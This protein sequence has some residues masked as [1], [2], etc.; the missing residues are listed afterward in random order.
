MDEITKKMLV[1][2]DDFE[3]LHEKTDS[4]RDSAALA[5]RV[6]QYAQ[7]LSIEHP[8]LDDAINHAHELFSE[9]EYSRALEVIGAAVEDI[10][11]GVFKQIE[12]SYY[13]EVGKR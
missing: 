10:E 12:D 13:R 9:F 8:E 2:Q 4:I 1:V 3:K 11:P 6:I 7:R 5:E